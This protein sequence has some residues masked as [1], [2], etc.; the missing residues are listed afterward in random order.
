M[1]K[2]EEG[3]RQLLM[4]DLEGWT[5]LRDAIHKDFT[6]QGFRGAI[7]FVDRIAELATA[8]GHHPDLEIHYNRV[9]VSLTTHDDGGVT[10]ADISLAA[11]IDGVVE[12]DDG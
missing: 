7:A 3:E 6:F 8:A 4:R 11:R 5:F 12:P 1:A 10:E 2:L 9:V